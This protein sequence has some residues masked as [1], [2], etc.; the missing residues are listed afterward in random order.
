MREFGSISEMIVHIAKMQVATTLALHHGLKKCAER[1]ERVAKGEIG[2]Y[3]PEAGQF[4]AWAQLADSTEFEKARLG[5]P[6]DAPL[7]RTG[8]LRESISHEIDGLEAVVGSTSDVMVYQELGDV[9]LPPRAVLG[10]AAVRSRKFI[11]KTIGRAAAE[12]ILYGSGVNMNLL[13]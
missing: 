13:D 5:Y 9:H 4:E 11:E 6:V 1:V 8:E 2:Q 10:P 3:Q 7:L 12:G